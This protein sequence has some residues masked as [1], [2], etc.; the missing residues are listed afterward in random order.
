MKETCR[1]TL[2]IIALI[3]ATLANIAGFLNRV[4]CFGCEWFEDQAENLEGS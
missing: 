3:L 2:I 4:L 1:Q